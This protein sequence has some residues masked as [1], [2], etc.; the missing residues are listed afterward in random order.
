M[1]WAAITKRNVMSTL[2]LRPSTRDAKAA[3]NRTIAYMYAQG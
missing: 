3:T 2:V 1:Y